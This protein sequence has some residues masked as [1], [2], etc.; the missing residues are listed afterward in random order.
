MAAIHAPT[1]GPIPTN[2][3]CIIQKSVVI[4]GSLCEH[5]HVHVHVIMDTQKCI[6]IL[7]HSRQQE[8]RH[9]YYY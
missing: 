8:R 3:H 6:I 5:I 4:F 7:L 9:C 2:G 1:T